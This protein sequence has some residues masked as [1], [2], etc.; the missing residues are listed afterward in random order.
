MTYETELFLHSRYALRPLKYLHSGRGSLDGPSSV[1]VGKQLSQVKPNR[2]L[3]HG[4]ALLNE[5]PSVKPLYHNN[6]RDAHVASMLYPTRHPSEVNF[7]L[8]TEE[9]RL[10]NKP[11]TGSLPQQSPTS[12]LPCPRSLNTRT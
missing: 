11:I 2:F 12:R 1:L 9:H 8:P 6:C 10:S 5:R 4:S 7:Y 3:T